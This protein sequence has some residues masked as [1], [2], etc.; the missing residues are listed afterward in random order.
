MA[1]LA[2]HRRLGQLIEALEPSIRDAFLAAI[3][4]VR[5]RAPVATIANL[6]EAGRVDDVMRVLGMDTAL[7]T[8]LAESVRAAFIAGGVHGAGEASTIQLALRPIITGRYAARPESPVLR[9]SFDMFNPRAQSWLS[10]RSSQLV[11]NIVSD[12]RTAIQQVLTT[13]M[14][15]GRNPRQTALDIVGRVGETGRRSG[16]IVGLTSQ[17]ERFVSNMRADLAS[18]DPK[19]MARYFR[20]ERRDKRYDAMVRRAMEAGKPVKASDIDKIAGRYSDRL[21]QLRGENIARTESIAS[22]NAAREEAFMQSVQA[23]TVLPEHVRK[24]W[25]ATGDKRTRDSHAALN[26][27]EV[28]LMEAFR[29]PTGAQMRYP[30]DTEMGAS[31]E[32]VAGCRCT[33]IYRVDMLAATMGSR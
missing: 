11:T 1:K 30:G 12:Q 17:Q 13:G 8:P 16:G 28:G 14:Q 32:D 18:G 2:T 5:G 27:A 4:A 9:A 31:A 6:I 3:E 25:G 19:L 15:L 20:R 10:Q 26:G 21:L 23:G 24:A 33:A 7:L 22:F 29:S